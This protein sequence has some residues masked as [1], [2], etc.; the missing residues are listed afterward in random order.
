MAE[1]T[2]AQLQVEIDR[3]RAENE[4]LRFSMQCLLDAGHHHSSAMKHSAKASEHAS[5]AAQA[6]GEALRQQFMPT[7]PN[8]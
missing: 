2:R 7:I 8:N 6:T 5:K 4:T 1:P 3:L